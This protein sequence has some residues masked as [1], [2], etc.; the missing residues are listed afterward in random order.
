MRI[1]HLGMDPLT[2][3]D[4]IKTLG[5]PRVAMRWLVMDQE[6][7]NQLVPIRS[8]PRCSETAL[9]VQGPEALELMMG[10]SHRR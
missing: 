9:V 2:V 10:V 4:G 5:G 8:G 7:R 6:L 1:V 3:S